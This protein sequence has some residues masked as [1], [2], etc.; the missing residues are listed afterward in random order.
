MC[1]LV[2]VCARECVGLCVRECVG[3]CVCV[4]ECV[5]LCVF[6]FSVREGGG[7]EVFFW[8]LLQMS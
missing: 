1:G 7:F 3:L 5:G 6:L 4:R 2:C 8:Y